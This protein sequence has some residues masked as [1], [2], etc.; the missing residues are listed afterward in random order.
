LEKFGISKSLE[1]AKEEMKKKIREIRD[2][3]ANKCDSS[4]FHC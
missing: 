1:E 4:L 3:K 2:L